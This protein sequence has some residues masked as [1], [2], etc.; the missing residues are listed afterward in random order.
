MWI[1]LYGS[2]LYYSDDDMATVKPYVDSAGKEVFRGDVILKIIAGS[3]NR[4]YISSQNGGVQSLNLTTG[5]LRSLLRTDESGEEIVGRDL[6]VRSN[7]ELW[8]GS[9]TG[10]YIYNLRTGR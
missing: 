3:H 7:G 4:L 2:G 10:I 5:E 6:L 8:I 9:E 1:G